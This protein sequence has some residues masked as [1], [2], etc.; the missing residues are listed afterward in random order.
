MNEMLIYHLIL[1]FHK[2]KKKVR[3]EQMMYY[4]IF[5]TKHAL[6]DCQEPWK[7][8]VVVFKEQ[9]WTCTDDSSTQTNHSLEL[10]LLTTTAPRRTIVFDQKQ[11][12]KTK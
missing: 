4:L 3:I 12:N 9:T 10:V 5:E 1:L 6:T 2:L 11:D 7:S 8:H